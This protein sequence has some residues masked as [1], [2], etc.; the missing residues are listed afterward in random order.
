LAQT[1]SPTAYSPRNSTRV[2]RA[3]LGLPASRWPPVGES[4][5]LLVNDVLSDYGDA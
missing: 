4:F 5:V 2:F 1:S 3:N